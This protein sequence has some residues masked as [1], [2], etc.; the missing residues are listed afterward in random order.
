MSVFASALRGLLDRGEPAVLVSVMEA[1]GS[2]P[3]E[4]DA[5][6]VV[7]RD[8]C[9]GT[10]G[11]GQLE[12][13][14]T[15]RARDILAG[16]PDDAI[17]PMPLGPALGQCC[18]GRVTLRFQL[19]TDAV[20]E[21]VAAEEAA[22]AAAEPLVLLFGAG[23]VGRAVANALAPLP[24]RLRWIDGRAHEFPDPPPG[25]A[26]IVVSQSPLDRVGAAP[27]GCLY[28][29][30]T[31]SHGLDYDICE[32]VLR[33][34]DFAWLGLIGSMTKRARFEKRFLAR[35]GSPAVLERLACPIGIG[36]VRDKRPAVIAAMVVAE[37]LIAASAAGRDAE[38]P[39]AAHG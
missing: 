34:G 19:L 26:E 13:E 15:R 20:L 6:M 23:H 27:A 17:A 30:M 2:T 18:G 28:L 7:T 1:R 11:G 33:R 5:R 31:H 21:A 8:V 3:R 4:S 22:H 16:G 25:G 37:M 24:M 29:V 32:A 9:L 12:Y 36:G 38:E 39:V 14:A 35:G 10:V